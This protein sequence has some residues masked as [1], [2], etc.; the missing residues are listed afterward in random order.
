MVAPA[1]PFPRSA[2]ESHAL[3]CG[4]YRPNLALR[5]DPIVYEAAT[6]KHPLL[7]RFPNQAGRPL[8]RSLQR[9]RL[10]RPASKTE[11]NLNSRRDRRK[12]RR[13]KA[14]TSLGPL[15]SCSLTAHPWRVT[16]WIVHPEKFIA[17][18]YR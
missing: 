2:N 5:H 18:G 12:A 13:G 11:R 10:N 6:L 3:N 1:A 9:G 15:P 7:C 16:Q 4:E 14:P 8:T 17:I